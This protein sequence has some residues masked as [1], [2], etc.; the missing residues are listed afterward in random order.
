MVCTW[1]AGLL[2]SLYVGEFGHS[3]I[4]MENIFALCKTL[5]LEV[6]KHSCTAFFLG[7][8]Q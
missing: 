4:L 6:V 1:F 2:S 5:T 7:C 3:V 8:V